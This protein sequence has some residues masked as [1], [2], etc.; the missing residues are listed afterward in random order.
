MHSFFRGASQSTEPTNPLICCNLANKFTWCKCATEA[1]ASLFIWC[2]A[3]K[4]QSQLAANLTSYGAN[5]KRTRINGAIRAD[6]LF[7]FYGATCV[8]PSVIDRG[9]AKGSVQ[10]DNCSSCPA[11]AMQV[12][13]EGEMCLVYTQTHA[14]THNCTQSFCLQ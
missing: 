10:T 12:S 13:D 4:L 14:H 6:C 5:M 8:L 3:L 1:V 9:C 11:E 2:N 7:V